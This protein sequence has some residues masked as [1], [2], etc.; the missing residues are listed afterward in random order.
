MT[1]HSVVRQAPDPRRDGPTIAGAERGIDPKTWRLI[2]VAVV[3]LDPIA[4]TS[5]ITAMLA[6]GATRIHANVFGPAAYGELPREPVAIDTDP[7]RPMSALLGAP[8]GG[9][10]A[11]LADEDPAPSAHEIDAYTDQRTGTRA[12]V[13]SQLPGRVPITA[14]QFERATALIAGRHGG[15]FADITPT[16]ADSLMPA[17]LNAARFVIAVASTDDVPAWLHDT[18]NPVQPFLDAG[19]LAIANLHGTTTT[20]YERYGVQTLSIGFHLSQ[21]PGP[22]FAP[23]GIDLLRAETA[24]I[25]AIIDAL[26]VALGAPDQMGA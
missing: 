2:P 21:Q 13:I 10:L 14:G 24:T 15:Y 6:I 19:R 11:A 3:P 7:A 25:T 16:T 1:L 8:T 12:T 18:P 17:A 20:V 22:L 4:P 9:D 23:Y 26:D 5:V